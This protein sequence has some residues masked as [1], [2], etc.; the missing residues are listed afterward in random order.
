MLKG[1]RLMGG[2]PRGNDAINKILDYFPKAIFVDETFGPTELIDELERRKSEGVSYVAVYARG[3]RRMDIM[4]DA[5]GEYLNRN[6]KQAERDKLKRLKLYVLET[7]VPHK[8]GPVESEYLQ[9]TL[10]ELE[11]QE[12]GLFP[13]MIASSK[14]QKTL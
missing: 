3:R 5:Y 4:E 9:L 1:S 14:K 2:G 10:R 6:I 12:F 7:K 8:I 13:D 11:L